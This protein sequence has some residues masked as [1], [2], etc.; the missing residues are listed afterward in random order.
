MY[1]R[2]SEAAEKRA[3]KETNL[4]GEGKGERKAI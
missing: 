2:V 3:D 4:F 1:A